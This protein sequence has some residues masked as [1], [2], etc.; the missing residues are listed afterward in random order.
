LI[1]AIGNTKKKFVR[2]ALSKNQLQPTPAIPT[3]ATVTTA[4]L[5][6]TPAKRTNL[7]NHPNPTIN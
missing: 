6:T 3:T 5:L 4:I 7:R 1:I 2:K